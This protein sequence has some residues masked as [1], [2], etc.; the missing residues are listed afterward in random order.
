M[1]DHRAKIA[2]AFDCP[3]LQNYKVGLLDP[4][5]LSNVHVCHYSTFSVLSSYMMDS[6]DEAIYTRMSSI[7]ASGG[8]PSIPS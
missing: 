2:G 8:R 1:T 7:K 6:M 3:E 4:Y 5:S